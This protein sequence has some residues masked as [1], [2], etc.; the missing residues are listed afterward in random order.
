MEKN[1][2]N[3]LLETFDGE[4]LEGNAWLYDKNRLS[5]LFN[6]TSVYFIVM[7]DT[8]DVSGT[9]KDRLFINKDLIIWAAPRE[10]KH[11]AHTIYT[12]NTEYVEISV[13]TVEGRTIEGKVNMQVFRNL[14]DMLRYTSLAPFVILI[15]A[16]DSQG[17]FHH[18]LFINKGSIM[19][20]EVILP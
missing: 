2:E 12:D 14:D 3:I 9:K 19:Q 11:T 16:H 20:I 4:T 18:T 13:R 17:N 6:D 5:E 8:T 1:Y 15:N 10:V 7:E